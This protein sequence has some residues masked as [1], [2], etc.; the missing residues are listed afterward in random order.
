M[1]A[2]QD[3]AAALFLVANH[4]PLLP[5]HVVTV[6]AATRLRLEG[7]LNE[8]L[9]ALNDRFNAGEAVMVDLHWLGARDATFVVQEVLAVFARAP[10]MNAPRLAFMCGRGMHSREGPKLLG[11]IKSELSHEKWGIFVAT[12]DRQ[13]GAYDLRHR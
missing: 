11:C 4:V 6:E 10:K 1:R 9:V 8:L 12:E 5:A 2:Q 3:R 13:R 7:A